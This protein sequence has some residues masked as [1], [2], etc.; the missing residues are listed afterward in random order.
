MCLRNEATQKMKKS[1]LIRCSRFEAIDTSD[2]RAPRRPRGR[3]PSHQKKLELGR[4]V[5]EKFR[6]LGG[7]GGKPVL[8][9]TLLSFSKRPLV[10]GSLVQQLAGTG[11]I[12]LNIRVKMASVKPRKDLHLLDRFQTN[13]FFHRAKP[14]LNRFVGNGRPMQDIRMGRCPPSLNQCRRS[15]PVI[16]KE[17]TRNR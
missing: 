6:Q 5:D 13:V 9:R 4:L 2:P 14:F 12:I 8:N 7:D 17:R 16:W 3:P 11:S 1:P 15:G 10:H